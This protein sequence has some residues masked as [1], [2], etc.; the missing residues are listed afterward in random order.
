MEN[1]LPTNFILLTNEAE[2]YFLLL[3]LASQK[4]LMYE[5][6]TLVLLTLT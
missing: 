3:F 4:L 6:L 2:S 5:S 1:I